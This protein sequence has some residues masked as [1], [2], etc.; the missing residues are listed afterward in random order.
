LKLNS[1]TPEGWI[2]NACIRKMR[3]YSLQKD[4]KLRDIVRV[5]S[6]EKTRFELAFLEQLSGIRSL[7]KA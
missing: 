4:G 1:L 7:K 5:R 6:L 3:D 2:K